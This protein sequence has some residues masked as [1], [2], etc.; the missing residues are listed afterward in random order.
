MPD[1]A[2]RR[3]HRATHQLAAA[4]RTDAVQPVFS[5]LSAKGTFIGANARVETGRRQ[6]AIAAFAVGAEFEHLLGRYG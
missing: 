4:V 6:I 2:G 1:Q 5:A 3:P